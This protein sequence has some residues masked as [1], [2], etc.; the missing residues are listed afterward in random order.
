MEKITLNDEMKAYEKVFTDVKVPD[1]QVVCVRLDGKGFS[2]FTRTLKGKGKPYNEEFSKIMIETMNFLMK[3]THAKLGYTQSDE[4]TMFYY[5]ETEVQ[6]GA[7]NNKVQKLSS[8][9]ASMATAKFNQ[10][11]H[12]RIPEKKDALAF[13]DC[14]TFAVPDLKTAS[15]VILWRQE[16]AIK[17]SISMAAGSFF[18]HKSLLNKNSQEKIDMLKEVGV[19]F[20]DYPAFFRMG[21]FAFH[22]TRFVPVNTDNLP[23]KAID[24]LNGVTEVERSFV[25]NDSLVRLKDVS[26]QD[27]E[28]V[29]FNRDKINDVKLKIK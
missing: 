27:W 22:E 28:N 19:D 29:L 14:R 15:R 9:L 23:P 5:N 21:T 10:E 1:D 4:I 25:K 24:K 12:A 16:D 8:I 13:F 11:L 17:N 26:S 3:N 7:F 6:S 18:S 20:N 2:K